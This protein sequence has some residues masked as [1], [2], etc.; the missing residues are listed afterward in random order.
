[1]WLK[2]SSSS[3]P[4]LVWKTNRTGTVFALL[5]SPTSG[6]NLSSLD[7]K[8]CSRIPAETLVDLVKALPSLARLNLSDTQCDAPVLAAVAS[9][10]QQ[11][12]E[13]DVV[14]CRRLSPECLLH[15]AYDPATGSLR[16]P[17]LKV[18]RARYLMRKPLPHCMLRHLVF[19]LL[20]L[21]GL[22]VLDHAF[23]PEAVCVIHRRQ[24]DDAPVAPEFPS[25]EQLARRRMSAHSSHRITLALTELD[26]VLLSCL[27]GVFAVCPHLADVTLILEGSPGFGQDFAPWRHISCL[28]L[29]CGDDS[30]WD[31][32][33]LLP[34]AAALGAQLHSL[35]LSNIFCDDA[36]SFWTLLGH[37]LNLRKFWVEFLTSEECESDEE[38]AVEALEGNFSPTP[39]QFPHL[40]NLSLMY[41]D[42]GYTIPS[43]NKAVLTAC[44]VSLLKHSPRLERLFLSCLPFSLDRVFE[45][46]LELPGAALTRLQKLS[47]TEARVSGSTIHL[48][49]S[50]ENQLSVIDLSACSRIFR[51]DYDDFLRRA[52]SEGL[53]LDILW[54]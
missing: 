50:S 45:K 36:S 51:A 52:R 39:H 34:M 27:P 8:G 7:I 18:L 31:V 9:H 28:T 14:D 10:C 33:N 54:E 47:L 19:L 30:S 53:E 16:C 21:R 46:L 11:L 49:L 24:F 5:Q 17:T 44:L 23:V 42:T 12:L 15:L 25:L 4:K 40:W 20:A 2:I 37:C 29:Q 38:E 26:K 32:E 6:C 3:G 48:L 1:M 43:Q 35:T 13:L 41:T 22:T